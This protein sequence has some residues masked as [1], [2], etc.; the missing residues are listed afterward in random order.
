MGIFGWRKESN[1]SEN[2]A[3]EIASAVKSALENLGYEVEI[4]ISRRN[5]GINIYKRV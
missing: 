1:I 2:E 4:K 3:I 5:L